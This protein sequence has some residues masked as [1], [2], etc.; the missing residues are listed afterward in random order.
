MEAK[1]GSEVQM[2]AAAGFSADE[3]ATL[4]RLIRTHEARLQ[5]LDATARTAAIVDAIYT[6]AAADPALAAA[7]K[8]AGN[9]AVWRKM[10]L[11]RQN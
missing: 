8:R 10:R 11:S 4:R 1:Q 2:W 6:D 5:G 3:L 7:L 9:I